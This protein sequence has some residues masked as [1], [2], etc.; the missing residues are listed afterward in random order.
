MRM[1]SV[2]KMLCVATTMAM[3]AQGASAEMVLKL[4]TVGRL[5]MP[6]GDAIDQALIPTL[7]EVSGG[8][9]IVEN[10]NGE[11]LIFCVYSSHLKTRIFRHLKTAT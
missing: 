8:E 11:C 5:G 10:A 2:G 7:A 1:K 3:M 9:M 6:I 4:G